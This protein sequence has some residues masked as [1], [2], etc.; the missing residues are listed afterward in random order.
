MLNEKK[1][2]LIA[3]EEDL[4]LLIKLGINL[5]SK[6]CHVD[7]LV[8]D[9]WNLIYRNNEV[10]RMLTSSGFS[11]FSLDLYE[12]LY[13]NINKLNRSGDSISVDWK[14]LDEYDKR[15]GFKYTIRDIIRTDLAV[16]NDFHHCDL[17]YFPKNSL[18]MFKYFEMHLKVLDD[19]PDYDLYFSISTQC[20]QKA[21]LYNIAKQK[22]VPYLVFDLNRINNLFQIF[23]NFTI[24]TTCEIQNEMKMLM[25]SKSHN[26]DA[27]NFI[28]KMG[29]SNG[30][31]YSSHLKIIQRSERESS[32][33]NLLVKLVWTLKTSF[34]IY[35]DRIKFS[36]PFIRD[37]CLPNTYS[38]FKYYLKNYIGIA[39]YNKI[40]KNFKLA[41]LEGDFVYF[42]LHAM[43]ETHLPL[44]SR[45]VD[46]I[47]CIKQLS[48]K[49]PPSWKILVKPPPKMVSIIGYSRP[50]HFYADIAK[51]P[52][53][54]FVD[55]D[56]NSLDLIRKSKFVASVA[57]T[58]LLEASILNK[59]GV[60][61]GDPEFSVVDSIVHFDDFQLDLLNMT[62]DS[63]VAYYIQAC[64]NKSIPFNFE[65]AVHG[66]SSEVEGP[67]YWFEAFINF[68]L[69]VIA[70]KLNL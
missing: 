21:A 3:V 64:I 35:R 63:N 66:D 51:I 30:P 23:D 58:A 12:N 60:R 48:F 61:W 7:I 42:P 18:L 54:I 67:E 32:F 33:Y 34:P 53:V 47:N 55:K 52:N 13:A 57:G 26:C 17:Y 31:L 46:E 38:V 8:A 25:E 16:G 70:K 37:I 29:D 28:S 59:I 6:G 49:I 20:K 14:Y 10:R 40:S 27:K 68:T 9:R 56:Y 39:R 69:K 15:D 41:D 62:R 45:S 4:K 11:D 2:L 24:G 19:L 36:P 44:R 5:R 50:Y 22:K 65:V 43:P 1:I